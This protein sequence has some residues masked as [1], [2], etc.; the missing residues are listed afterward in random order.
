MG[1][2]LNYCFCTVVGGPLLLSDFS[3]RGAAD[4]CEGQQGSGSPQVGATEHVPDIASLLS[5]LRLQ[6]GNQ[7]K[8]KSW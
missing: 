1:K 2:A 3:F 8:R 4:N 7:K 5:T 6:A